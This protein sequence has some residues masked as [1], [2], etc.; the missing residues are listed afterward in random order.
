M[1]PVG[2][3]YNECTMRKIRSSL[4]A[5]T[6]YQRFMIAA[7]VILF[8]GMLGI[9]AWVEQQI[10]TGVIHRTGATTALYVDSFISPN[11]QELAVS[12]DLLPEHVD[13][14]GRL[15]HDTPMGRQIVALKIWDTR[16]R[17]LYSNDRTA[18]GGTFPMGEG[19]LRARLG[20]VVSKVSTLDQAENQNLGQQYDHLLE[21]YSPVWRSGTDQVIAVAEFYQST[22]ALEREI[23]AIQRR[24]WLV[25]GASIGLIYL[26][27]AGFV[28]G[29]SR[30]ITRQQQ[31]LS[32]QVS[33]LTDLLAQNQ[34]LHER[35]RR[36]AASVTL[37]NESYLRRIGAELH[38]G[39]AQELGLSLLKLD[40]LSAQIE[41]Q[42]RAGGAV[43][44]QLG[45]IQSMLRS[46]LKEMRATAAGLSLPQLAELGLN[47][48][49]AR[50]VLAHERR[51]GTGV[52]LEVGD[53]PESAV[54]PL[55][56]TIYRL[57]QEALNNAYHH[58]GGQ[59]QSVRVGCEEGLL[60]VEISD[61]GA[62]FD[63]AESGVRRGRLGLVG[64]RERVES[65]GGWFAIE[66]V[67]GRGTT[68]RAKLPC[69]ID[70]GEGI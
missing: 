40:A 69:A 36:A 43:V 47:E 46:A 24:T 1:Q 21:I 4:A 45:A 15:L 30:T 39:P 2:F 60:L 6:L 28:R 34:L 29:A 16:G 8:L 18:V 33:Q 17:V 58:A 44:E 62:G 57:I 14:L 19:L 31:A 12:T 13:A 41:E 32:Q 9:G 63:L 59:G 70:V 52:I 56:V 54:Q 42:P 5:L 23:G 22:E 10:V 48:T 55:K 68:I 51:T 11:V 67:P 37:L 64:M 66:S 35:I 3:L 27:L 25:V 26:L 53:I 50:A 65:L 7:L 49:I 61:T 20:D 38:D